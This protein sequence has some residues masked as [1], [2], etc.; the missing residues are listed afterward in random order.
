MA[1]PVN[2]EKFIEICINKGFEIGIK[3]EEI[4]MILLNEFNHQELNYSFGNYFAKT[5]CK[6]LEYNGFGSYS[7]LNQ[8]FIF[9]QENP[10][11]IKALLDKVK[12]EKS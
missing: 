12:T 2:L 10:F 7:N 6:R 9:N 11:F 8:E 3:L 1:E 5:F 4:K